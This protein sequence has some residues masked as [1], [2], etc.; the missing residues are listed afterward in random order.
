M[1]RMIIGVLFLILFVGCASNFDKGSNLMNEGKYEEA[2]GY[3]K[4]SSK[5]SIDTDRKLGIAYYKSN[6]YKRAEEK[7]KSIL[8][9]VPNERIAHFYLGMTYESEGMYKK[10]VEEYRNY[11]SLC[12]FDDIKEQLLARIELLEQRAIIQEIE[13]K[14]Q[15]ETDI[16][17][18]NVEPNTFAVKFFEK[19]Y[20]PEELDA[21]EEGFT[22]L[23]ISDFM[24]I[25][26]IEVIEWTKMQNLITEIKLRDENF[27][28]ANPENSPRIGKILGTSNI[29]TG[30]LEGIDGKPNI[31]K[32]TAVCGQIDGSQ[33]DPVQ[34]EDFLANLFKLEKDI[35]VQL[36][37]SVGIEISPEELAELGQPTQKLDAFLAYSRGLNQM[38]QGAFDEAAKEFQNAIAIDKNF[39][40]AREKLMVVQ[41][42]STAINQ[43]IGDIEKS[44]I[45]SERYIQS[46]YERGIKSNSVL[47]KSFMQF[48]GSNYDVSDNPKDE[49]DSV[50]V[51]FTIKW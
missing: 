8:D 1:N 50:D 26:E 40:S 48:P 15:E 31:V 10:A 4:A 45:K 21:L 16:S 11:I 7:L 41:N 25:E 9:K 17:I 14:L 19:L 46:A 6:Q 44:V 22:E 30:T 47:S 29:I 51:D 13:K 23:L 12:I 36:L 49:A 35:L 33:H 37:D 39:A 34:E 20:G 42:L 43:N 27:S 38:T 24:E 18:D 2:I 3:L 32:V 5:E 28:L